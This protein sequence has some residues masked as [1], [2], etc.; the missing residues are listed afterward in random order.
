[1]RLWPSFIAT[2][3][4]ALILLACAQGTAPREGSFPTPQELDQL[5]QESPSESPFPVD[6]LDVPSWELEEPLV[7]RLG[8]TPRAPATVW[9]GF[10][11]EAVARREGLVLATEEMHCVAREIGR[12]HVTHRRRPASGLLRFIA[13]R[14]GV[15]A[16][17]VSFGN[18]Q[19]SVPRSFSEDRLFEQWRSTL[20]EVTES[21]LVGGPRFVGIWFG[22]QED[23]A[24]AIV[25]AVEREVRVDPIATILGE[26]RRFV[27]RGEALV[28]VDRMRVLINRG[29]HRVVECAPN[30]EVAL[31][32]FEFEC[33]AAQRDPTA[34]VAVS[35]LPP[36]RVL[37]R[38]VLEI[39]L[40]APGERADV[41][42]RP[43]QIASLPVADPERLPEEMTALVN[44]LRRE[45]E[46]VP[47]RVAPEQSRVASELA[48]HFF[49]ALFGQ[50]KQE[51]L[52]LVLL[53]MMAG[54]QVDGIIQRSQVSFTWVSASND[55]G[56]LLAEALD[57]PMS[58]E[59]LMDPRCEKIAIGALAG[60]SD[61]SLPALTALIASYAMFSEASH[62]KMQ[63]EIFE[64]FTRARAERG[65]GPPDRLSELDAI[66][67]DAANRV[68]SG[69]DRKRALSWLIDESVDVLQRAVN[70][71]V[72]E[73]T[74][75]D[76]LEFPEDFLT[77]RRLGLAIGVSHHRPEGEPWGRYVVMLV[78]AEPEHRTAAGRPK[79]G[80]APL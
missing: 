38:S 55:V 45:A 39:L 66:V 62:A 56:R 42:R 12:F 9:D 64:R 72:F 69:E 41:Y 32:S 6:V 65:L 46:F 60:E 67:I 25:A 51:F 80:L 49:S 35:L 24:V 44:R 47:L 34:W 10:F 26:D 27:L 4:P 57:H 36:G 31:P 77:R 11:A 63:A 73:V 78:V 61:S 43:P 48:P 30:P 17:A 50:T 74:D 8:A 3:L 20:R 14:C 79:D 5:R 29:R 54:W 28:P 40:R 53:G 70:G 22:R 18:V 71:W 52:D 16:A 19:G 59:T 1:M 7:D 2:L 68:E 37:A 21:Q 76:Q 23:Y 15:P 33:E 75:L 13:A 58:R